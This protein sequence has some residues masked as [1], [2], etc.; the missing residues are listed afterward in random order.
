MSDGF[1]QP[2]ELVAVPV[3]FGLL[4]ALVDGW[5]G[6]R[7]VLM[8]TFGLVAFV[9]ACLAAYYRYQARMDALDEERSWARK[10]GE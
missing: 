9:G 6:T 8:L 7:P 2:I 1:S 3:L 10:A 4:G 5:V